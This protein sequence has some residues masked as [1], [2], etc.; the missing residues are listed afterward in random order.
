MVAEKVGVP[1]GEVEELLGKILGE[2]DSGKDEEVG[3]LH[4]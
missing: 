4:G 2:G 1:V 3:G